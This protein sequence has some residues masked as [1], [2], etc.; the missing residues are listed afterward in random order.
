MAMCFQESC[1]VFAKPGGNSRPSNT[2]PVSVQPHG[3]TPY[4]TSNTPGMPPYPPTPPPSYFSSF[5]QS[6]GTV[7]PEHLKASVLS[8]VEHKVRQRLRE[9]LGTVHAELASIRQTYTDLRAGQQKLRSVLD[10]LAEEQKRMKDAL[11]LLQEKKAEISSLL[12]LS[13]SEKSV[14][15]DQVIDACTPLHRQLLRCYVYDCAIDDA[16]YFL[17]QALSRGR[18]S[19]TNYLKEVRQLSRQQ[20]IHRATLQKCRVK[21]KMPL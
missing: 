16:I 17:G 15:I 10:E 19:L 20:F 7:Q 13:S 5:S 12:A 14:E 3:Y 21:A 18:I 8:A 11:V 9:K 4:P 2:G 6:S 1:P